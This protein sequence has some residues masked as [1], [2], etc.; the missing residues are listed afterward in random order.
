VRSAAQ[1]GPSQQI[2]PEEIAVI[3][4]AKREE[5]ER[6]LSASRQN[7]WVGN[8]RAFNDLTTT[9]SF[10]WAPNSGFMIWRE[11]CS[12]PGVAQVNYGN[13]K[14]ELGA[15]KLAPLRIE[16]DRHTY[17]VAGDLIPV[18]W[19]Q[20]HWL[21]PR[22][23]IKLFI[24]AINSGSIEEMETFL[25]KT[26]D[27]EK[28]RKGLPQVS[29]EYRKFLRMPPIKATL[30]AVGE[31][32]TRWYPSLTLDAGKSQSVIPGMKFYLTSPRGILFEIEVTRVNKQTSEAHVVKAGLFGEGEIEIEPA[33]GWKF[34]SRAPNLF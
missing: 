21:I 5:V 3:A 16:N 20:Q 23:E 29:S 14:F 25:L 22:N 12:R 31:K 9:T 1:V 17:E 15:V 4:T 26:E 27:Y 2:I 32:P 7:E 11:S 30:S 18:K 19:G 6:E 10:A 28:T 33:V 34:S 13:A 24:Y 8:Y